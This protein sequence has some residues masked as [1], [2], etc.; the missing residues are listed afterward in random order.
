MPCRKCTCSDSSR[1]RE[2]ENIQLIGFATSVNFYDLGDFAKKMLAGNYWK[3]GA[4]CGLW[5][6]RRRRKN[7]ISVSLILSLCRNVVNC[8]NHQSTPGHTHIFIRALLRRDD[9]G[10]I[11]GMRDVHCW[12]SSRLLSA[13]HRYSATDD[14]IKYIFPVHMHAMPLYPENRWRIGGFSAASHLM[15][16]GPP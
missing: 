8:R 2:R 14:A 5:I 15:K 1:S 3:T 6:Y 4:C 12:L 13:A 9:C 16:Y 10:D 11:P 7:A